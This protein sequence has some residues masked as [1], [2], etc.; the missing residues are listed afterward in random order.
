MTEKQ[1]LNRFLVRQFEDCPGKDYVTKRQYYF[2]DANTTNDEVNSDVELAWQALVIPGCEISMSMKIIA[3]DESKKDPVTK[4]PNPRCTG[5][6]AGIPN[7]GMFS[8]QTCHLTY[9]LLRGELERE[10]IGDE[11]QYTSEILGMIP[12]RR[13]LVGP[14][15]SP[16]ILGVG[17]KIASFNRIHLTTP[18]VRETAGVDTQSMIDKFAQ[19]R[20]GRGFRKWFCCN[21]GQGWLNFHTHLCCPHC[22]IQRCE[23]CTYVQIDGVVHQNLRSLIFTAVT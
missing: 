20:G 12:R 23:D 4:C 22:Q 18:R 14:A 10:L 1:N 17:D 15:P 5:R 9:S 7:K 13:R 11:P 16:M 8:C 2:L 6:S 21:C 3:T 19:R